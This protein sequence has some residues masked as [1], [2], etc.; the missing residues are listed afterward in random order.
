MSLADFYVCGKCDYKTKITK[1]MDDH[2]RT[3]EH[4]KHYEHLR[5][6]TCEIQFFAKVKFQAH[7]ET[8]KHKRLSNII[9]NCELC[10]Y[11]TTKQN[12]MDQHNGTKKH[13]NAVNGVKPPMY[14]C[15]ECNLRTKYKSVYEQ[16]MNNKRHTT[17]QPAKQVYECTICNFKFNRKGHY[18][19]H[20]ASK[21]HQAKINGTFIEKQTYECETCNFKFKT[22]NQY[23]GHLAS[24]SHQGKTLPP[25][26]AQTYE[27]TLCNYKCGSKQL[28]EQHESSKKHMN[29]VA[30]VTKPVYEC[31]ECN[32]RTCYKSVYEQHMNTKKHKKDSLLAKTD[33]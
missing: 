10:G 9:M 3:P 30:G 16:H 7:L 24:K 19:S 6:D 5:C 28:I 23:E 8:S 32:I 31:L 15:L 4:L 33:L 18:D 26:E 14:E 13:L 20:L 22:R 11:M 21:R 25:P 27:C 1:E 17:E 12:Q 2:W 29:A